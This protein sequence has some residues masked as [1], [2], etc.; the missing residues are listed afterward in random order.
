MDSS[1]IAFLYHFNC[2]IVFAIRDM[3]NRADN[4]TVDEITFTANVTFLLI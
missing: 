2:R 3:T 4:I 1:I